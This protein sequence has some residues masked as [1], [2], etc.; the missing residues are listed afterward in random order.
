MAGSHLLNTV[1]LAVADGLFGLCGS[2]R[3]DEL[4]ISTPFPSLISL[5]VSVDVKHHERRRKRG[6]AWGWCSECHLTCVSPRGGSALSG[7]SDGEDVSL[8]RGEA[9]SDR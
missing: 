7:L 5:M 9:E 1:V 4:F 6:E 8:F 3:L 2:E